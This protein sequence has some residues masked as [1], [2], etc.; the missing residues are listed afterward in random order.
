V[1]IAEDSRFD[2]AKDRREVLQAQELLNAAGRAGRA[3]Q[4]AN[5]IV[6]VIPGKVVGIDLKDATIGSELD[7]VAKGLRPV[8][9]VLGDRRPVNGHSRPRACRGA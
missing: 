1:I 6:L 5:G 3:G 2:Q 7:G 8:R 9:P 4:N